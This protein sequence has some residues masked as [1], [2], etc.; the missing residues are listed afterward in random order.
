MNQIPENL[1]EKVEKWRNFARVRPPHIETPEMGQ[2][3]VWDYPRPPRVEAV[4]KPVRV[5]FAGITLASSQSALRVLET[6]GAPVYYLP[7]RDVRLQ[8]LEPSPH[9]TLCE[10]KGVSQYWSVKVGDRVALNAAWSYPQPWAGYEALQ[11]YIAFYPGLM[12]ACFVGN[13]RVRPQPGHYYGGWITSDIV[14]PFKGEPGSE[15][16]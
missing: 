2:E 1:K 5:E 16:W 13:E 14:G 4:L 11:D 12:D 7:P 6:A 15:N 10:W 8:Y 9:S 3:S